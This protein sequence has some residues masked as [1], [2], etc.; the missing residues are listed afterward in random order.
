MK[1]NK[2]LVIGDVNIDIIINGLKNMPE[3]GQET[4]VDNIFVRTGGGAANTAAGLAKLDCDVSL[5][6]TIGNDQLGTFIKKNLTSVGVDLSLLR[7]HETLPTGISVS[8][9]N[10]SDRMFITGMGATPEITPASLDEE[11]LSQFSHIHLSVWNPRLSLKQYRATAEKAHKLGCTVSLDV[12]WTDENWNQDEIFALLKETDVFFPNFREAK[13]LCWPTATEDQM[14]QYLLEYVKD[15]VVI[16]KG[17]EG[18]VAF[19]GRDKYSDKYVTNAI[20]SVGAG[21]AFNAGFISAYVHKLP[22]K[23]CLSYGCAVGSASVCKV[24][25]GSI[26]ISWEFLATSVN[27]HLMK[28]DI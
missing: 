23:I 9:S 1:Y 8:I 4:F 6:G 7:I 25:G 10:D 18:A 3:M 26:P 21:D 12:G 19:H 13:C 16:T 27:D 5:Y 2:V 15:V 17:S 11:T 24:G 20:D 14:G 28:K 22:L